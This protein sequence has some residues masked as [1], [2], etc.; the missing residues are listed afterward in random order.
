MSDDPNSDNLYAAMEAFLGGTVHEWPIPP[1]E[2]PGFLNRWDRQV[3]K[4]IN[5][6]LELALLPT[7]DEGFRRRWWEEYRFGQIHEDAGGFLW[8]CWCRAM[9]QPNVFLTRYGRG[10]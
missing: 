1:R 3:E 7:I 5:E 2:K 6:A 4:Q 9:Q 8:R 10:Y